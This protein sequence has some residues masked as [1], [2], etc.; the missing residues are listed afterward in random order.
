MISM[1]SVAQSK[2]VPAQIRA[3][4][5]NQ[6]NIPMT[7]AKA[8]EMAGK[9]FAKGRFDDAANLSRQI[10]AR[11]PKMTDAANLLAA[12]LGSAGNYKEAISISR[13]LVKA[14]PN[15]P[16][17]L[18]NLGE[19]ERRAGNLANAR[20][21]FARA[22]GLQPNNAQALNNL[23]IV[24]FEEDHFEDALVSYDKAI[25]LKPAFAEAHNNRGNALRALGRNEEAIEAY[26]SALAHREI[27]AEAYNNLGT[28]LRDGDLIAE[29]EHAY[30]KAISQRPNYVEAHVNLAG[31]L[32]ANN[33][34]VEAL[35]VLGDA[36][37][38]EDKH[39]GA[40][41]M[42]ARV[43]AGRNSF[44]NAERAARIVIAGDPTK[45][46]AMV[47]L[48]QILHDQD[49]YD[50]AVALLEKAVSINP[51]SAEARNFLGVVLKSVGRLDEARESL[52]EGHRLAP[53]NWGT[54][55]NLNDLVNFSEAPDL[56]TEMKAALDESD[57]TNLKRFIPLHYAYAKALDD[58][59]Q[60]EK[61]IEHYTIGA[62][63]K[64][65]ELK[66]DE[67]RSIDFFDSI[68]QIY[69]ADFLANAPFK[70]MPDERPTFIIGM[71]RSGSTL[72]EQI[73]SS[74]PDVYGAGEVKYL[75][76]SLQLVRDRFP[77]LPVFPEMATKLDGMHLEAI[78]TSYL[79][80]LSAHADAEKRITDKLLTNYF[81]VGMAHMLF[82]KAK[83]IHT[84][85]NP[86]DTCLSA[87]TKLFKDD[88]P[89]SYDFG[90]LGR[91]YKRYE[92]LMAHWEK[93]LPQG[94]LLTMDYEKVVEDIEGSARSLIDFMGLPFDAK[95][96]NFH[97]SDRPV[98]T[99]SVAQVRKPVYKTS[100]E[101]WR[102]YGP[103]LQ[104]LI[105]SLG[106]QG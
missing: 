49:R 31:L 16:A 101:R 106:Y 71:P 86:V 8:V 13:K 40:L 103:A 70:G 42:T 41:I 6:K 58:L 102:R 63:L 88:M 92:K 1:T 97:Q 23:G 66:Y 65:A 93:V 43:Q 94:A 77:G 100:V 55:A 75:S 14:M 3:S 47:V 12:S 11:H 89:H 32:H 2:D 48:G 21:A 52:L 15:N 104:P 50:E 10:L 54:L 91:Y 4:E 34:D 74:H 22:I 81:F 5:A 25:G 7:P 26:Q 76:R 82:P 46:E 98:K 73:L 61:A 62:N 17:L 44:E 38:I 59:G 39:A 30:R 90:E 83:F 95:C 60:P 68:E 51:K 84:R 37:R 87:F 96:V 20:V 35:R 53:R 19:Y 27:Y 99:A 72:V 33:Q 29:A 28:S 56:V 9:L 24:H 80:Q 64:R 67:A 45:T 69:T 78:A 36:L 18:S 105:D 79:E 57:D 85:R